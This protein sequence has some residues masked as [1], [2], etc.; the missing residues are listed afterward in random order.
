MNSFVNSLAFYVISAGVVIDVFAAAALFR[1]RGLEQRLI[2]STRLI[3]LGTA[4][5]LGGVAIQRGLTPCGIKALI[6]IAFIFLSSPLEA[7]VLLRAFTRG[8]KIKDTEKES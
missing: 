2:M 7:H 4:L 1:F 8:Q 6:C 5:I 3:T